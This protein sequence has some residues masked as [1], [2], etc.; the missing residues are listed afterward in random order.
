MCACSC[1]LLHKS[2]MV[3]AHFKYFKLTQVNVG[4]F[5]VLYN[6]NVGKTLDYIN[7][8]IWTFSSNCSKVTT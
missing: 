5:I 8:Q 6:L 2:T 7:D 4:G 1:V 3:K